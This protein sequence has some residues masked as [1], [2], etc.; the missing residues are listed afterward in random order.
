[1]MEREKEEVHLIS[2]HLFYSLLPFLELIPPSFV[3]KLTLLPQTKN[4]PDLCD[5]QR[6]R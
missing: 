1:M 3:S 2:S 6:K 5:E 4:C